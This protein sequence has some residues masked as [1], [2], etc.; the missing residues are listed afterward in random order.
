M[1]RR[2]DFVAERV[3]EGV[4]AAMVSPDQVVRLACLDIAATVRLSGDSGAEI[5]VRAKA[6]EDYVAGAAGGKT[7]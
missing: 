1:A 7:G 6:F 3:A 4:G 5:I 2:R